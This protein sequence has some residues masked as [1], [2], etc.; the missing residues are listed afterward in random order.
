MH[1]LACP[2]CN[3]PH[4]YDLR[5][6]LL[7]CP[8]CSATF[9]IDMETGLKEAYPEHYIVPNV[10]DAKTTRE[11]VLEWLKRIHH[12]PGAVEKE[13]FVVDLKGLSIPFWVVSAEVHT[14]WKGLI[15]K[16]R[17]TTFDV[18]A[19]ADFISESGTFRRTYRW[20]VSA[21]GN[22]CEMWGMARLHEPKE[23]MSVEWDGF[24]LDSTLSRG[25]L[26]E[27]PNERP[28]Y[29]VREFFDFKFANSLKILGM[30][31]TEDEALRRA[32]LHIELY[33]WKL[34]RL[35]T[36]YLIDHRTEID[37]A[38]IQLLHL[39]FWFARYVYSPKN[40]LRHFV[41]K[42][43]RHVI[44]DG[45]GRSL[46]KGE[47]GIIRND[48]L[49]VNAIICAVASVFL[50]LIGLLWHPAFFFVGVF[51]F[52]IA[53]ASGFIASNKKPISDM[54]AEA[55]KLTTEHKVPGLNHA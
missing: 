52:I 50:F 11:L 55:K 38:G 53:G 17:R 34:A 24:P 35:N 15:R 33:H 8:F 37:V 45:Y 14:T 13:F 3:S 29:D 4:S 6:C 39:P 16:A 54:E 47:L 43:E 19:G 18:G 41:K 5:D 51:G 9:S 1:E 27:V 26:I 36:D 46:L 21:R 48:K 28:I 49:V 31:V 30:Q 2:S 12:K 44:M 22:I 10:V 42:T 32:R 23:E 40:S 20:A 7:M 25:K